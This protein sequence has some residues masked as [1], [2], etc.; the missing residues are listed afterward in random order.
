[1][2]WHTRGFIDKDM[3]GSRLSMADNSECRDS[4]EK[5]RIGKKD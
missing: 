1:M 2:A 5:A 4:M 3:A